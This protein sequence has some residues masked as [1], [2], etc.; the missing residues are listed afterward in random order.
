MRR[1][2]QTS[3]GSDSCSAELLGHQAAEPAGSGKRQSQMDFWT[4][5]LPQHVR[6]VGLLEKYPLAMEG[7]WD[8]LVF[9]PASKPELSSF[10]QFK[11]PILHYIG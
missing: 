9:Y 6:P 11:K 8:L 3:R 4:G 2:K 7:W 1:R 10:S 5:V